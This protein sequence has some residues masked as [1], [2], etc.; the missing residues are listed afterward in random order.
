MLKSKKYDKATTAMEIL[1]DVDL[2]E[3][4][5]LITGTTNGI[6][7]ETARTLAI[8]GAHVIMANRNLKLSE[9]LRAEIYKETVFR[10]INIIQMDLSSLESIKHGVEMFFWNKWPLHVLILNAGVS[11]TPDSTTKEGYEALF[12]VNHLGHFYLT[13]LL[14]D[15][16]RESAPSRLVVVSSDLHAYT[17]ID[18]NSTI[19]EKLKKLIPSVED[20]KLIDA[21]RFYC[22]SK[23]C[24]VL[25]AFKAHRSEHKNGIN[26]YVLHPGIIPDS[27]NY[28]SI[29]KYPHF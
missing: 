8:K 14:M 16:L 21:M 9:E 11:W 19:E 4:T 15:K 29:S 1:Q 26:T 17:K 10:R 24:N 13:H 7:K 20:A 25:F 6:G 18:P 28:S 5:I 2:T 27:C 22:R 12:G 23:L 3:K